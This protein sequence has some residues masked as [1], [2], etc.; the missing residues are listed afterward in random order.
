MKLHIEVY[1]QND[2]S[3][4]RNTLTMKIDKIK[5]M[6]KIEDD[7]KY[8]TYVARYMGKCYDIVL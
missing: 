6:M 2:N 1:Q 5:F 3:E 4:G 8:T 7:R